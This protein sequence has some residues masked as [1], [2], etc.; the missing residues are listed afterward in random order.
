LTQWKILLTQTAIDALSGI[1]DQRTQQSI[2]NRINKLDTEPDK[3]GKA[4]LGPLSGYRSVRAAGQ[5]YRI[6]HKLDQGQVI[7][8]VVLLGI[9]REGDKSDI[10]ALAQK[11]VKLGLLEPD[12]TP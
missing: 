8:Y 6:I 10:Y 11:L 12:S 3:Q 9:R 1:T 2:T 7:V 4:L 5:R